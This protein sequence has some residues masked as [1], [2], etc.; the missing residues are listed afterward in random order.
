MPP[1]PRRV[2]IFNQGN[3]VPGDD[4]F[5]L[6]GG[7]L[8]PDPCVEVPVFSMGFDLGAELATTP[9]L[10]MTIDLETEIELIET[11]NVLADSAT[12][13]ADRTVVVG[14]HLDSVPEGPGINDN[15]SGI[16]SDPRDRHA[17]GGRRHLEN[18]VRFAFWGGEEDGL[19]GSDYYVS[20]LTPGTQEPRRQP[21]LR[22][23]GL[24]EL[25]S[26]RLRRR[27]VGVR[28]QG[29][30]RIGPGRVGVQR[31]LRIEGSGHRA[32]GVRRTVRLLRLHQR[33]HPGRWAVHRRRRDQ[34][35]R[36][37]GDLRRHRRGRR[38]TRATTPR[39]TRSPTSAI[40]RSTRCRTP[41]PTVS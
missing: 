19:I 29:A 30:E 13:R 2:I 4:R 31:V 27:R 20:Q 15:G 41:S 25:R 18:R 6:F 40:R 17:D 32:H 11:F 16:G 3:D 22:H 38:T 21:E 24:A 33:R 9:G 37:G 12:G 28:A 39:A 1:E 23:G 8:D 35:R 36:A 34:D 14:A 10:V 26:L 5:G 7:T